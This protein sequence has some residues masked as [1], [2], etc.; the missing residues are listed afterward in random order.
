MYIRISRR[1]DAIDQ[2]LVNS[3]STNLLVKRGAIRKVIFRIKLSYRIGSIWQGHIVS[4]VA[5]VTFMRF[6]T[7]NS[8]GINWYCLIRLVVIFMV[9]SALRSVGIH[10][11]T[12]PR[13]ACLPSKY[14][15]S[16][17]P[18]MVVISNFL[19][20]GNPRVFASEI[21]WHWIGGPLWQWILIGHCNQIV[22]VVVCHVILKNVIR[23]VV[24]ILTTSSWWIQ[25]LPMH[26]LKVLG[27]GS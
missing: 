19:S 21:C 22:I 18:S 13:A 8:N 26:G 24:Q 5:S 9:P 10:V 27:V 25:R 20:S 16:S 7:K 17:L 11:T 12:P 2:E 15:L 4:Q 23:S 3:I 6:S 1:S 14:F